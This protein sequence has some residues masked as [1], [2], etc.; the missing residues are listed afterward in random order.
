MYLHR[1]ACCGIYEIDDLQRQRTPLTNMRQF[2]TAIAPVPCAYGPYGPSVRVR[3]QFRYAIFSGTARAKYGDRFAAFILDHQLGEVI[4]T[5]YHI[6]PNSGH[7]LKV[8]VWT[9][10]HVALKAWSAQNMPAPAGVNNAR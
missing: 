3:D 4:S 6:N 9:I 5:G 1:M 10:D 8:W 7:R 2:V